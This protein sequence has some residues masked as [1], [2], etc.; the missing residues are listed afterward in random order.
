[1]KTITAVIRAHMLDNVLHALERCDH[2]PGVTV[3]ACHGESRGR[4]AGGAFR[5]EPDLSMRQMS[6]L[7]IYCRDEH[8]QYLTEAISKTAHTGNPGDGVI[9]VTDLAEVSRIRSGEQGDAAV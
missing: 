9:A 4:G 3:C 7:E 1:M 6:R 8:C 5:A 2:F